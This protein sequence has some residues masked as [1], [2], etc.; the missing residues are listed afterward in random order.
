MAKIDNGVMALD[1]KELGLLKAHKNFEIIALE[2]PGQFLLRK[3]NEP[4]KEEIAEAKVLEMVEGLS[5]SE[6]VEGKLEEKLKDEELKAFK[7]LMGEGKIFVFKLNESYKKGVYRVK[8]ELIGNGSGKGLSVNEL[9]V[10]AGVNGIKKTPSNKIFES[11]NFLAPEKP[12]NDYSLE[13]D[14]F[15]MSKSPDK[16]KELSYTFEQEIREG[17]LKGLK[18]FEGNYVLIN[19]ELLAKISEKILTQLTKKNHSMLDD[20]TK[21]LNVSRLLVKNVCEFLKEDGEI[22]EKKKCDYRYIK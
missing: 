14:G 5:L 6:L 13:K 9:N 16:A 2:E 11:E 7:K 22:I 21:E 19:T 20:I 8:K 15:I 17:T 18:T 1:A 10:G 4:T 3:K 12:I